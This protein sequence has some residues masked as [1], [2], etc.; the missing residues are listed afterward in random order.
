[1]EYKRRQ[2]EDTEVGLKNACENV[3]QTVWINSLG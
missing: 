2:K 1:M 3:E